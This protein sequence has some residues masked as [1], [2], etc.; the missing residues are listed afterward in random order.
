M[1]TRHRVHVIRGGRA[2]L[3][4][5]QPLVSVHRA[6]STYYTRIVDRQRGQ[7]HT[8]DDVV[9]WAWDLACQQGMVATIPGNILERC[10]A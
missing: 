4:V 3:L 10:V 7:F 5:G 1:L 6:P 2:D 9:L 8:W